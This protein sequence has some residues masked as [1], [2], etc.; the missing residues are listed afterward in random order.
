M[1]GCSKVRVPDNLISSF[2]ELDV[3]LGQMLS[4]PDQKVHKVYDTLCDACLKSD[5]FVRRKT[6]NL[7]GPAPQRRL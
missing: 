6:N 1:L 2:L 7:V 4:L 5:P 3:G